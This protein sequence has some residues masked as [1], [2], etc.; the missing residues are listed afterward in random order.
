M[1]SAIAVTTPV[2]DEYV[3]Y[4]LPQC[5]ILIRLSL[6]LFLI[7]IAAFCHVNRLQHIVKLVFFP[8]GIDRPAFSL[9]VRF[10]RSMPWSFFII[11]AALFRISISNRSLCICFCNASIAAFSASLSSGGLGALERVTFVSSPLPRS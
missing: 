4:L 1:D 8:Q 7:E 2:L 3:P 6:Y 5:K 9:F 11:S 10:R